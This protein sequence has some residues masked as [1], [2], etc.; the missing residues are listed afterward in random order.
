MLDVAAAPVAVGVALLGRRLWALAGI[1]LSSSFSSAFLATG[2]LLPDL[3]SFAGIFL[4]PSSLDF[5]V[6]V[7]GFLSAYA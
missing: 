3:V 7:A 2:F 1:F 6:V 4:S 5:A